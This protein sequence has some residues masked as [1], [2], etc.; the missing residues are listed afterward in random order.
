MQRL[1]LTLAVYFAISVPAYAWNKAGHMVSAAI[2]HAVLK[3]EHPEAIPKIVALLKQHPQYESTWA[4]RLD[5]LQ[6][7]SEENREIYLFMLAA[8]W[9]DD[10]RDTSEYHHGDWHFISLPYLHPNHA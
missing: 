9:P 10:I 6:V 4:K 3:Q 5:D 1:L 8:R 2:A 7:P